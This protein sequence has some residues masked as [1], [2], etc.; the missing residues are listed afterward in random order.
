MNNLLKIKQME[1]KKSKT[2]FQ[3]TP[4][5]KVDIL[6]QKGSVT[7]RN[8]CIKFPRFDVPLCNI[9]TFYKN[10]RN[11][12]NNNI[13][14]ITLCCGIALV[15]AA[16]SNPPSRKNFDYEISQGNLEVAQKIALTEGV[17]AETDATTELLWSLEAGA[18]LRMTNQLDRSTKVFDGAE[19][20]I[21]DNETQ[22]LAAS[23][24]SQAASM[25]VNDNIMDYTPR[26]YDRVMV[27]TYKALN[28]WQQSDFANARVEWNRVDDRQ[29][30]AAEYFS[31]EINAQKNE[32]KSNK[33]GESYSKSMET[34]E[35]SGIDVSKWAPYDGYIN[36]ASLYLHGLYFLIN[37]ESAADLNKAKESLK[38]AYA[39][40]RSKQIRA[41]LN[42]ANKGRSVAPGVWVIFENGTS[43]KKVERR[44]DLPLIL[45]T[46]RVAYAG[47]ALPTLES[48]SPAFSNLSVNGG[49]KTESFANMDKI[50]QGEFKT[51]FTGILIKELARAVLKTA[52]QASM[53]NSDNSTVR[54][55][56]AITGIAQ[57]VTTQADIRSWHT[58]PYDFQVTYVKWPKSG[59][60]QLSP[61]GGAPITVD[62]P[63]TPQPVVVYVRAL[64]ASTTPQVNVLTSKNAM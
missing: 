54:I 64:N 57:A 10:N 29:R 40:T 25:V 7:L 1:V 39:L 38:R 4:Q 45:V 15:L 62:L 5:K 17:T 47:I 34:L 41:D 35:G 2:A 61:S 52:A 21:K 51:E 11:T 43:S 32:V 18:L 3:F 31:K 6:P 53:M 56:G 55:L 36:P 50:I 59:Q 42:L 44:V 14:R 22:N 49:G 23:G 27:N 13:K 20:L 26:V 63:A 24:F 48:G 37:N 33:L 46:S 12:M 8:D 60:V 9:V 16:C 30:R 28:F 19:N 58:L